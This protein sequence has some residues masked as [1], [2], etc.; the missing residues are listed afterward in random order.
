MHVH[1]MI[2]PQRLCCGTYPKELVQKRVSEPTEILGCARRDLVD[3][4]VR[5]IRNR[6]VFFA[7]K[8]NTLCSRPR[9]LWV[10]DLV[11]IHPRNTG[12]SHPIGDPVESLQVIEGRV[13]DVQYQILRV[14]G[15]CGQAA[16]A[17]EVAFACG[18]TFGF[19]HF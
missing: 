1:R 12:R 16:S 18:T 3:H 11:F 8:R 9:H 4:Y 5:F 14:R 17:T 2:I 19:N 13:K 10:C 15:F 7:E 6:T